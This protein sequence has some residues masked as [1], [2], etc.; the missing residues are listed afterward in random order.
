MQGRHLLVGL[1][2][3]MAA[4]ATLVPGRMAGDA[5]GALI[6]MGARARVLGNIAPFQ[7]ALIAEAHGFGQAGAF[8]VVRVARRDDVLDLDDF[9]GQVF[10]D[11]GILNDFVP[12]ALET[13][14]AEG[15]AQSFQVASTLG[16]GGPGASQVRPFADGAVAIG[17]LNLD[18]RPH[19]AVQFRVAVKW[20]STQCMPFSR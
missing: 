7:G 10:F 20:Q 16:R 4:E 12:L 3:Q 6:G 19:L 5:A 1:L 11:H 8:V 9:P 13:A 18:G 15:S 17:A 14:F 2:R